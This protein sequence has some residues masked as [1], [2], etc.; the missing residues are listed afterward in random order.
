M[1]VSLSLVSS[2]FEDKIPYTA[3]GNYNEGEEK[4]SPKYGVR[5]NLEGCVG[6]GHMDTE[7]GERSV[8]SVTFKATDVVCSSQ[9]VE[10]HPARLTDRVRMNYNG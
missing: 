7:P 9:Y 1:K 6:T 4:L 5:G 3:V 8:A 10:P 2:H